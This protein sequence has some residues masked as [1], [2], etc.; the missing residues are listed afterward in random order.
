V[1]LRAELTQVDSAASTV[2]EGMGGEAP[3]GFDT[4]RALHRVFHDKNGAAYRQAR[5]GVINPVLNSAGA[6]NLVN[7]IHI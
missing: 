7:R 5:G 6:S 2:T 4:L 1:P 3:R